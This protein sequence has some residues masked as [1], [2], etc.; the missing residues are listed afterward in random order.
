MAKLQNKTCVSVL[1]SILGIDLANVASFAQHIGKSESWLKKASAGIIQLN[2]RTASAIAYETGV[3][4]D[5]LLAGDT[6]KPPVDSDG[7]PYTIHSYALAREKISQTATSG[8][9]SKLEAKI[10]ESLRLLIRVF[11]HSVSCNQAGMFSL[12]VEKFA[13]EMAIRFGASSSDVRSSANAI[14]QNLVVGIHQPEI[15]DPEYERVLIESY[16]KELGEKLDGLR[17]QKNQ[18]IQTEKV[19]SLTSG[20]G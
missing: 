1:R 5:W 14:L 2:R 3:S 12:C 6:S 20:A 15:L 7:R 18:K 4:L 17:R 9:Q 16:T 10:T 19:R 8:N 13:R 11:S